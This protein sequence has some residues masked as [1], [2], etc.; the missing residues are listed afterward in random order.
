[1]E[2]LNSSSLKRQENKNSPEK[3]ISASK[4]ANKML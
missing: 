2:I 4:K 1:M 3:E